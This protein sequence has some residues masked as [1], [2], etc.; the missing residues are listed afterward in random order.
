M[1]FDKIVSSTSDY[2]CTG[3]KN[4]REIET[5]SWTKNIYSN[6]T[7]FIAQFDFAKKDWNF[8]EGRKSEDRVIGKI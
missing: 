4:I 2:W 5:D 7:E 3:S 1:I 6:G 8:F